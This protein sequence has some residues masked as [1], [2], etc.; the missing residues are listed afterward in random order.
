MVTFDYLSDTYPRIEVIRIV[1]IVL[2]VIILT[3]AYTISCVRRRA[4]NHPP[5]PIGVPILG[6]YPFVRSDAYNQMIELTNKYKSPLIRINL[7]GEEF[8]FL[9]T[10]EA[11][12]EAFGTKSAKFSGRQLTFNLLAFIESNAITSNEG[13]DWSIH[14]KFLFNNLI[15]Q[16]MGQ[17]RTD[18][19]VQDVGREVIRSI[20]RKMKGDFDCFDILTVGATNVVTQLFY[21][22]RYSMDDEDYMKMKEANETI[23]QNWPHLDSFLSGSL[24]H[25]WK[26]VLGSSKKQI[27]ESYK[28]LKDIFMKEVHERVVKRTLDASSCVNEADRDYLDSFLSEYLN[29]TESFGLEKV[30]DIL[31]NMFLAGTETTSSTLYFALNFMA[32]YP[33][34]QRKVY[35]EIT[36]KLGHSHE[37]GIDDRG[38]LPFTEAVIDEVHRFACILPFGLVRCN[39]DE[40]QVSGYLIK[41]RTNVIANSYAVTRDDRF[42]KYPNE[43]NPYNFYNDSD[44]THL[45]VD[46]HMPFS[47][48]KRNCV[49][50]PLARQELFIFFVQLI[51]TFEWLPPDGQ[52]KCE[53]EVMEQLPRY[54]MPYKVQAVERK[55]MN[56]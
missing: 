46:A 24:L 39:F 18:Q 50:E 14:R 28:Q 38:L 49:G 55:I 3:S 22:K 35:E 12:K 51:R 56:F 27:F 21:S 40:E 52:M 7:L 10:Y 16:G 32:S 45:K 41:K 31:V 48:G 2:F 20:R 17:S 43:F 19:L 37:P 42:F 1:L 5:G 53:Y 44:G 29:E 15:K 23:L 6:Y 4:L 33:E 11:I 26:G 25:F 54:L 9:N 30:S 47:I 8:V 34:F 13:T 36:G